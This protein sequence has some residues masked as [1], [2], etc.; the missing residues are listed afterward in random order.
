MLGLSGGLL[1]C[2]WMFRELHYLDRNWIYG[3]GKPGNIIG[4][5][6]LFGTLIKLKIQNRISLKG[7]VYA[8]P[9]CRK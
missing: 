8:A 5:Y 3:F 2:I 1:N 9:L 7:L 4:R 6:K